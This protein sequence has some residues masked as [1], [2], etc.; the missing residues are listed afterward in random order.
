MSN[1]SITSSFPFTSD[2]MLP[3]IFE[4][5]VDIVILGIIVQAKAVF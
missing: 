5:L 3:D 2:E 1:M 4:W